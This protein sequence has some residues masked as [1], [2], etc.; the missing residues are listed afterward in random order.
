MEETVKIPAKEFKMIIFK[1]AAIAG[2]LYVIY[3]LLMKAAGLAHITELRFVNY[4]LFAIAGSLEI[5]T[6]KEKSANRIHY[7]QGLGVTFITGLLSF[8]IMGV[9]IF[10]YSF[11]DPF[12]IDAVSHMYPAAKPFAHLSAPFLVVSEGIA[13]SAIIS[14]CLMQYFKKYSIQIRKIKKPELFRKQHSISH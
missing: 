1:Y 4:L 5:Q 10:I 9:F 11:F 8:L 13:Y 3:F 2:F 7:L 6:I 14:F 12:F